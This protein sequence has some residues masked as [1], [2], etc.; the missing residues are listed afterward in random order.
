MQIAL[1]HN[2]KSKGFEV[3]NNATLLQ[4]VGDHTTA[5]ATKE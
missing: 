5:R 1:P 3:G 2:A 4:I